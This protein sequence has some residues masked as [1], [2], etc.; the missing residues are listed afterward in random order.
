MRA[1]ITIN[2]GRPIIELTTENDFE[3][4]LITEFYDFVSTYNIYAIIC[5]MSKKPIY[6]GFTKHPLSHALYEK[7]NKSAEGATD[8]LYKWNLEIKKK[9]LT[10]EIKLIERVFTTEPQA[11]RNKYII[12]FRDAGLTILNKKS[13]HGRWRRDIPQ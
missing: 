7:I 6:I 12:A 11:Y 9:K 2:E 8:E 1:S 10:P 4:Y 13:Q 3:K 5:P